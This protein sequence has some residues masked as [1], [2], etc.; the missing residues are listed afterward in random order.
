MSIP[1]FKS[2]LKNDIHD[3]CVLRYGDGIGHRTPVWVMTAF[4]RYLFENNIQDPHLTREVIDGYLQGISHLA[5]KTRSNYNSTVRQFCKLLAYSHADCYIP[6][7]VKRVEAAH[8]PYIFTREEVHALAFQAGKLLPRRSL[9]GETLKTLFI[10]LYVTGLRIGEALALN[11]EDFYPEEFRLLVRNGKFHKARWLPI[12]PSTCVAL[13]SY[14][15]LRQERALL[16]P[17]FSLFINTRNKRLLYNSVQAPFQELFQSEVGKG[18]IAHIHDLRHSFA[19]ACLLRWYRDGQDINA[20]LPALATYMGHVEIR[21][22][23][24]YLHATPELMQAVYQRS[25]DYVR[26]HVFEKGGSI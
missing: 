24:I 9:R 14:L 15:K 1:T 8:T 4:D 22:T 13:E 23:Q 12:S 25:L 26:A 2:C 18:Q 17:G 10:L 3:F 7:P 16:T 20:R 6:D 19:V 5:S 21:S 11:I